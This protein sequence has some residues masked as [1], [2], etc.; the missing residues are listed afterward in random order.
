MVAPLVRSKMRLNP[1]SFSKH[2]PQFMQLT[3]QALCIQ[4]N[5]LQNAVSPIRDGP[6]PMALYAF[7]PLTTGHGNL[8]LRM[9]ALIRSSIA[10]LPLKLTAPG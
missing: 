7:Q 5:P 10:A 4:L 9:S 2:V 6:K 1:S 8:R 3:T